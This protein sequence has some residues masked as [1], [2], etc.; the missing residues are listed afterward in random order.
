MFSLD[1]D[2]MIVGVDLQTINMSSHNT[3][4]ITNSGSLSWQYSTLDHND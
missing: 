1:Q 4:T 3:G 2:K